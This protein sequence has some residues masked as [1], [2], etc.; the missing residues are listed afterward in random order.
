VKKPWQAPGGVII[1]RRKLTEGEWA[2]HLEAIEAKLKTFEQ[3]Y[4]AATTDEE[5]A[6][7]ALSAFNMCPTRPL[8]GWLY[9]ATS[10]LWAAQLP[11]VL[12]NELAFV[13]GDA[14]LRA[15]YKDK[16][17]S[18]QQ[19]EI[20]TAKAFK[21]YKHMEVE[22]ATETE[23]RDLRKE[24]EQRA[25]ETLRRTRSRYRAKL[26]RKPGKRRGRRRPAK[27]Y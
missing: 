10:D 2:G 25:L 11:P 19:A 12:Q 22:G 15:E 1:S 13:V 6:W 20:E 5:R 17:L 7:Y 4:K 14:Q 3:Q 8:P 21:F 27:R 18:G 24:A 9:A 26:R 16:G 23:Q